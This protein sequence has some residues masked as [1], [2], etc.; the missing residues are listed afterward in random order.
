M[1]INGMTVVDSHVHLLPGRL[2]QKVRAFFDAGVSSS[3]TLAYP[4][5]HPVVID[6][7]AREGV[8]AIWTL[9]YAHKAGVA[10]GLNAASAETVTQFAQS[11]VRV[12][13][14]LT[15][16]PADENPVAIVR[17]AVDVLG[18]RVLKLHCSV[19]N[20]AVDDVRLEP[21][22]TFASERHLP[23]VVHLGHNVN[24][25]TDAEELPAIG[26]VA[27]KFPGMPLILAHCG[28]HA[29]PEAIALMDLHP[30]LHADL[31][32]VVTEHPTITAEHIARH[33]DRIL[34]G[35]DCP[36][37]TLSVTACIAWLTNMNVPQDVLQKVLGGN[38]LRLTAAVITD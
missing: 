6:T 24:G 12:I 4:N 1:A 30:S 37:T 21:V 18:L 15:I 25:R 33:P 17:Q 9:P 27:D 10:E 7:L 23:A 2:G 11:P 31:T 19:G 26:E 36:N 29:A 5:D 20:F 38:A 3:F 35:S 14:G 34:F 8:D 32:P 13:G 28:H 16:H 22:F